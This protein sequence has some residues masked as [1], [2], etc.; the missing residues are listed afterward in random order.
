MSGRLVRVLVAWAAVVV[1]PI[2]WVVGA[3]AR[4]TVFEG[5]YDPV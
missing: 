3:Q 5:F 2:G 4:V 1:G